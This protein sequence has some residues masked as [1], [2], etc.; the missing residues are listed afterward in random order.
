[1]N[2]NFS[3]EIVSKLNEF[4]GRSLRKFNLNGLDHI[5]VYGNEP[6][7]IKLTNR[8]YERVQV[9]L[10]MDGTCVA[11]GKLA[12]TSP[13]SDGMWLIEANSS[14]TLKAWPETSKSGAQFVF[15]STDN[16]VAGNTHGNL[17]SKGIIAA[18][19]FT[20]GSRTYHPYTKTGGLRLS[21]VARGYGLDTPKGVSTMDSLITSNISDDL[22]GCDMERSEVPVASAAC[23]APSSSKRLQSS[24]SIGAGQ[25]VEQNI[26]EVQGLV[27][28]VFSQIVRLK[29]VWWSELVEQ[30]K[31]N[32]SRT[33][34]LES[35][36]F[37][38]NN[39]P[40]PM[41]NLGT[42]PRIETQKNVILFERFV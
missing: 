40:K 6:F 11:T 4:N 10:S 20:E 12:D 24:A 23:A 27:Q 7:L 42:T 14:M 8:S 29:Y 22:L 3:I 21:T 25:Q 39:E 36:G 41:V 13:T 5:G 19:V 35:L 16:S 32:D 33:R 18:A 31:L 15:T 34:E 38:G 17:S 28:P 9:K 30:L 26:Q 2:N 1:M 37:P